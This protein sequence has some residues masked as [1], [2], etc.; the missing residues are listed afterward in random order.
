MKYYDGK[1]SKEEYE[2][3]ILKSL[4]ANGFNVEGRHIVMWFYIKLLKQIK[5]FI[6]IIKNLIY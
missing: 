5:I 4:K 6:K 3:V 1:V 2:K